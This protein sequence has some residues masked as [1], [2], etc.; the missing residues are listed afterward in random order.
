MFLPAWQW[1]WGG[2]RRMLWCFNIQGYSFFWE[3][4]EQP[5]IQASIIQKSAVVPL[6]EDTAMYLA[7]NFP[8][9]LSSVGVF[10]TKL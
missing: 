1:W 6:K 7:S 8:Y 3:W 2:R 5:S 10:E 4:Q 9:F